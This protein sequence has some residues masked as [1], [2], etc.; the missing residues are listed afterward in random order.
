LA[1]GARLES[2]LGATPREFESRI[3][4]QCSDAQRRTR[5]SPIASPAEPTNNTVEPTNNTAEPTQSSAHRL[6]PG[7]GQ[8]A[9]TAGSRVVRYVGPALLA[10]SFIAIAISAGLGPS[11]TEAP[12]GSHDSLATPPWHGTATPSPWLVSGLLAFA[13]LCGVVA[14]WLGLSGRWRP[15]PRRLVAAGVFAAATLA[16]LPPIG[17]A[18]PL[19]YAAYGRMVTTG[20]NPWTTTPAQLAAHDPVERAVEVPWQNTPSVYGP[21]ATVEQAGA[22]GIAGRDVA[23][24]VLLLDLAGAAVFIGAGLLLQRMAT[25]EAAKLRSAL[26]WTANPLLWLQLVAGAHLDVIAA[27]AV[28]LTVAVAARS[29]LAAGAMAGAAAAIK[30]PAGLVLLALV[31]AARRSRR[32]VVELV[33]GAAV[34][35]GTGY[36]IAGRGALRQLSRASRLISLGT[37]WRP[38]AR[39]TDPALGHGAS[40][41]V[42]G[43]L[44]LVLFAAVV[45]ALK[46]ANPEVR[47]G[48]PV[49]VAFALSFGY[50]ISAPYA[51]P[52]YDAVPWVLLPLLAASRL[53]ALLVV[54]TGVLSLAYIPGRAAY[55]LHGAMHTVAFGMRDVIS[56]I[57]LTAVLIVLAIASMRHAQRPAGLP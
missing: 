12:L 26:L 43:I 18:D 46:R 28:L 50:V 44:A 1:Y 45:V 53:D 4:R 21:L 23:L 47:A 13:V 16:L 51:L 5:R 14:L 55:Q 2:V 19:S 6:A 33:I 7:P 11:A 35:A 22:S 39:L 27:G 38:V 9:G 30:A 57:L 20:H 24:T 40:R 52:W 32:A 15:S 25:T 37:P 48:S 10:L 54:H 49:A 29:R 56:P 17:S 8:S 3:L 34:V 36:A 42:I 31:W 41:H